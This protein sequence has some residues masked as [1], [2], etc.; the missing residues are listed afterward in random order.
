MLTKKNSAFKALL[1]ALSYL[2][3]GCAIAEERKPPLSYLHQDQKKNAIKQNA[4]KQ[5]PPIISRGVQMPTPSPIFNE[6]LAS[7]KGIPPG[8]HNN[9]NH[10][11]SRYIPIGTSRKQV[12]T[13]LNQM[14]HHCIK[15]EKIIHTGY[16]GNNPPFTPNPAISITFHFNESD[17]L[18][19][20]EAKYIYLQ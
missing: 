2:L 5:Q 13:I 4:I 1:P 3:A 16:K 20:I 9:V 14:N 6:I 19:T 15:K 18:E 17:L 7:A 12:Q 10:I 11:V 8:A